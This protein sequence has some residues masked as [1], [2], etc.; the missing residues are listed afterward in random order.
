MKCKTCQSKSLV[1][2]GFSSLKKQI[3]LC[4]DCKK[5]Q[6]LGFD[7]RKKYD[8]KIIQTAFILFSESN[9][10]RRIARVLSQIFEQKI[11]Y[12]TVIKWIQKK[13]DEMPENL[14]KIKDFRDI[15]VLEMDEL[16]TYVKKNPNEVKENQ[17]NQTQNWQNH[18]IFQVKNDLMK[19]KNQK[20][21]EWK[22]IPEFGLLLT[23]TGTK[24]LHL[25]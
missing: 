3:F 21:K 19:A 22:N 15:E 7:N 16:Y 11:Y 6:L 1:K 2:R 4:K 9:N 17:K 24:L 12:Q 13:V 23:A 18:Q 8:E 25:K 14:N 10:Y 20:K 5:Y